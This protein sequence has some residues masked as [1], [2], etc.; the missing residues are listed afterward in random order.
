MTINQLIEQGT[1]ILDQAGV[2]TP[3]LDTELLLQHLLGVGRAYLY[4]HPEEEVGGDILQEW[5]TRLERR[6]R[7][8]PLAYILGKAGF[9]GLEFAVTPDVLVPR[10]ETEVLVEAVL[11]KQPATVADI[12]TGSG[13]IAVAVAVNLPRVRVWAT[14]IS[15]AALRVARE[16]AQR[17]GVAQR[18]CFLQGDLLQP[19]AGL[20][21]EVI[22][23]NPP[24]V[25]ESER[26]SL[27]P[28][29][30]NWEP[31]HALFTGGDALQ[32]HRRL[33][34]EAH[35]HLQE[36]GWL[37]MEVGMGQAEAVASLLEESG[38]TAVRILNDL[39]GIGR[40]VEGRYRSSRRKEGNYGTSHTGS[41]GFS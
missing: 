32:F 19:L 14:D 10:P 15:E 35:F 3:R 21:V 22:A 4:A 16:N 12:G 13:C 38:Y 39:A 6:A 20:R 8:E 23:S 18:V 24:Y 40:V 41:I 17:H 36:S 34:A 37:M 9:Y 28:E 5:Q 27:Q 1:R 33:A 26:L 30:R 7:R 25:A 31:P 29:V 2:D 11:G